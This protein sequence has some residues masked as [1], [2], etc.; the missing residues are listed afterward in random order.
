MRRRPPAS[1]RVVS[2]VMKKVRARDTTEEMAVRRA[3][4]SRGIRYRVCYRPT[5]PAIGRASI[6]IAIPR[7]AL[8]VFIDGC[9]WYCCPAH[10]AVPMANHGW[11]QRKLLENRTRD[12][13]LSA[14][15]RGGGWTVLRYWTHESPHAVCK[16]VE[17]TIEQLRGQ[18]KGQ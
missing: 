18:A 11:W 5:S 7:L 6:D 16:S 15:L 12:E 8:A 13:R 4:H 14:T 9:F 1:S 2:R 10:G 3:L 17:Q